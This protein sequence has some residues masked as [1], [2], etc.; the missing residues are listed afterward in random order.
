MDFYRKDTK[1]HELDLNEYKPATPIVPV[2]KEQPTPVDAETYKSY[3]RPNRLGKVVGSSE[4]F[5]EEDEAYPNNP[6]QNRS[7]TP[8]RPIE[9]DWQEDE[10]PGVLTNLWRLITW[11]FRLGCRGCGCLF[12]ILFLSFI[13]IAAYVFV[14]K[15]PFLWNPLINFVNADVQNTVAQLEQRPT[16]SF[17]EATAELSA[18]TQDFNIGVNTLEIN[19]LQ[20][21][22]LFDNS[23]GGFLPSKLYTDIVGDQ[24]LLL[25]NI[26]QT[27]QQGVWVQIKVGI[28]SQNLLELTHVGFP[29]ISLP[30]FLNRIL[31]D[32]LLASLSL[33]SGR[34]VNDILDSILNLP[35]NVN[36]Q[37]VQILN[38][39]LR[40][41]IEL[42]SGLDNLFN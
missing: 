7:K 33:Q 31:T 39:T 28:N 6:K 26:D 34:N 21:Q 3:N 17:A 10:A 4:D 18:Q 19:E 2:G 41:N 35:P 22:A 38:D 36:I 23:F 27:V 24:I 32:A 16:P 1:N 13:A 25:W 37:S 9:D 15:P 40:V 14:S 11:P 8:R 5:V 20:L 29:N 12:L 42:K 30:Q